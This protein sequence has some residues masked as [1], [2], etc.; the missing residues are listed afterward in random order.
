MRPAR[1]DNPCEKE[2]DM[3]ALQ[4]LIWEECVNGRKD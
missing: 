3:E 4:K 1:K 2:V